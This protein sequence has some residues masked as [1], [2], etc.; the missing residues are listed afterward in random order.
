VYDDISINDKRIWLNNVLNSNFDMNTEDIIINMTFQLTK[1]LQHQHCVVEKKKFKSL[2]RRL[3]DYIIL[4]INNLNNG[5]LMTLLESNFIK[6]YRNGPFNV[7]KI[8]LMMDECMSSS[9]GLHA[10]EQFSNL[11]RSIKLSGVK[12]IIP[13]RTIISQY[14]KYI[15]T[16]MTN[17]INCRI[18]DH[19]RGVVFDIIS[20]ISSIIRLSPSAQS[21]KFTMNDSLSSNFNINDKAIVL[22]VTNDGAKCTNQTGMLLYAIKFPDIHILNE[23]KLGQNKDTFNHNKV[24]EYDIV[25]KDPLIIDWK[26]VQSMKFLGLV[27]WI[28]GKDNYETNY[29]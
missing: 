3:Q 8:A 28:E 17:Y 10:I 22:A 21:R 5:S 26:G 20:C 7:A 24:I 29:Q 4:L 23:M 12:N 1:N 16:G 6:K 2:S 11:S 27:G 9:I 13:S 18:I 19:G 15:E 25:D 14:N